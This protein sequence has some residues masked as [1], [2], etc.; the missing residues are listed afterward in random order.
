MTAALSSLT[1]PTIAHFRT[2]LPVSMESTRTLTEAHELMRSNQVRHLPIIDGGV[3]VGLLS[4]SDLH[5]IETLKDVNPGEVE[6]GDAMSHAPF[7]VFFDAQIDEVAEEMAQRKISSAV[8]MDCNRVVGIFTS[9]DALRALAF[10]VREQPRR[11]IL[12]VLWPV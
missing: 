1:I 2:L 4:L 11:A 12:A 5:L 8:V 3:L 6:I 10:A 9:V 7:A